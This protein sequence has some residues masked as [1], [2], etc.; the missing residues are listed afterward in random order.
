MPRDLLVIGGGGHARVLIDTARSR[1]DAWRVAGFVDPR[2]CEDDAGPLGVRWLGDDSE[3]FRLVH[4]TADLSVI[5][6]VG[7]V[8]ST[9]RR[10]EIVARYER[11]GVR[12]ASIVHARAWVSPSAQLGAGVLVCAGAVV[13]AGA[14]I[15]DH[16]VV[17]TGAIVEHDVVLGD[18][19][20]VAPGAVVG[21]GTAIGEATYLGLGCRV[22][23]HVQIGPRALVA[24]GAVVAESVDAGQRV[25][26]VPARPVPRRSDA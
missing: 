18:F 22:R 20:Q 12:W 4:S 9:S 16:C 1:P 7:A 14:V 17:N 11:R 6:G 10:Q 2:G 19:V 25:M 13:N 8:G 23:D 15:G 21:G 3:A 5:L 24:M 26:G